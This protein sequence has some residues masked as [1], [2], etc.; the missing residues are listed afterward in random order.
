MVEGLF[1]QWAFTLVFSALAAHS[2]LRIVT[3]RSSPVALV[4]HAF[5]LAMSL[6]MVAMAW[7]WWEMVPW[8]AQIVVFSAATL[9]YAA[10][11]L[12]GSRRVSLG[13]GPHPRWHQLMHAVMMGAMVWMVAAM[14]P[15][16]H[17]HELSSASFAVGAILVAA[18]VLFGIATAWQVFASLRRRQARN[19]LIDEVAATAMNIGMAGMCALML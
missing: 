4:G 17:H 2:L 13:T 3:D 10:L 6:D 16:G 14:P 5:H 9:W 7:P 19:I 1:L 8:R 15:G 18:L 11:A 12:F